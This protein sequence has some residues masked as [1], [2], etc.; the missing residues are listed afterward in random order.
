MGAG[1]Y[2]LVYAGWD[3]WH[4]RALAIKEFLPRAFAGRAL[5]SLV[6]MSHPRKAPVYR[7]LLSHFMGEAEVLTPLRG[8]S[9]VVTLLDVFQQHKTAYLAIERLYGSSLKAYL[10]LGLGGLKNPVTRLRLNAEEAQQL[11]QS[12]LAIVARLHRRNPPVLHLDL[13]PGNLFLRKQQCN[14]VVLLDFGLARLGT[15]AKRHLLKYPLFYRIGAGTP[16][17]VAPELLLG[18]GPLGPATDFYVLAATLYTA[19]TGHVPPTVE[20]RL[21]GQPLLSLQQ[22]CPELEAGFIH[23]LENCLQLVYYRRPQTVQALWPFA[24]PLPQKRR[25]LWRRW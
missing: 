10:G 6:V 1:G 18:Q 21:Q 25:F 2:G 5:D 13:T 20:Q 9:G 3:S 7:Q 24:L 19:I 16:G 14:Q 8:I 11:W 23:T 12:A 4:Q 15:V 17:F 22:A